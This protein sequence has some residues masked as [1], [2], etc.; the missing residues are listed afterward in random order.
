VILKELDAEEGGKALGRVDERA[1][2]D[3]PEKQSQIT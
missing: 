1:S 3:W 2:N